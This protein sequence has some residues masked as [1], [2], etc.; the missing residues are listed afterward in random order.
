MKK[1][2][3]GLV[4]LASTS[5]A[6]AAVTCFNFVNGQ[7]PQKIANF[8]FGAPATRVCV[9]PVNVVFSDSIGD[10]AQVGH[11]I[12]GAGRCAGVC[13]EFTL[14]YGNINGENVDLSGA[15]ISITAEVDAHLGMLNGVLTIQA[16]R[17]FP[18]KFLILG[19]N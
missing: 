6:S 18:E 1:Y 19:A 16:G 14:N 2:I 17:N 15:T 7:G 5:G 4:I 12:T 9:S 13:H 11:E 3:L 8:A 10:L